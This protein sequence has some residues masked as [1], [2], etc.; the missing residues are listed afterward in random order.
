[1]RFPTRLSNSDLILFA[2]FTF[3]FAVIVAHA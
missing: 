2:F 3:L 1:M